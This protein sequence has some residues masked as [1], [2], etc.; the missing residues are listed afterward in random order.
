MQGVSSVA[1]VGLYS[2][3]R[4]HRALRL[5]L[6]VTIPHEAPNQGGQGGNPACLSFSLFSSHFNS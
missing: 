5:G 6:P 2:S 1:P 4:T 3:L